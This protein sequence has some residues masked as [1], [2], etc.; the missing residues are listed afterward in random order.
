MDAALRFGG[1]H[2]LH[3]VRTGLELQAPVGAVAVDARDHFLVAAQFRRA[4][5][6]QF[7]APAARFRVPRV[8]AQKVAG[9]QRAFV[10]AR[11]RADFQEHAAA[12]IGVARQQQQLQRA[13]QAFQLATARFDL[14][15]RH[16]LH[17]GVR[18]HFLRG[19]QVF[20][21]PGKGSERLDPGFQF[22]AFARKLAETV[23]IGR[24]FRVG[25]QRVHLGQAVTQMLQPAAHG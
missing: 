18:Q 8:H 20:L 16:R 23:H 4:F 22:G 6:H 3:A 21:G 15:F 17:V 14:V 5:R 19:R 2:A 9:E 25:Q 12:V 7:H 10:A 1:G 11:A 24:G 13:F